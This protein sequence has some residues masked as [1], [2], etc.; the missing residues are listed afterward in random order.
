MKHNLILIII[1]TV[2]FQIYSADKVCRN[3][4]GTEVDWY[5]LFFMPKSASSDNQ[6]YYAYIDNTLNSLQYYLY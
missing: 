2:F 4:K 5:V 3:P 1:L 6:I